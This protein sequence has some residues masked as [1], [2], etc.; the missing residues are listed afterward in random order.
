MTIHKLTF[1]LEQIFKIILVLF[2]VIINI[3]KNRT[4]IISKICSKINVN[5][6]K[7]HYIYSVYIDDKN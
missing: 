4:N 1:I 7:M 6:C 2:F 5:L 3:H